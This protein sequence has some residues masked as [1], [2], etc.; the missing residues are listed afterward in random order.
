MIIYHFINV[1]VKSID[2]LLIY[3]TNLYTIQMYNVIIYHMI[4]ALFSRNNL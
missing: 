2:N 1:H 4:N 3:C